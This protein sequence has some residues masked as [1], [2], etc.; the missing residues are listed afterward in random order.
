M[1]SFI[2]REKRGRANLQSATTHNG[3]EDHRACFCTRKQSW[4]Y[5]L[6][7][8]FIL[9]PLPFFVSVLSLFLW[10]FSFHPFFPHPFLFSSLLLLFLFYVLFLCEEMKALLI[11]LKER[12]KRELT[13]MNCTI[14]QDPSD[15]KDFTIMQTVF[16][17]LKSLYCICLLFTS[18]PLPSPLPP[19][20]PSP[21]TLPLPFPLPHNFLHYLCSGNAMICIISTFN[22][23]Q[24][25]SLLQR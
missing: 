19:P 9:L 21:L 14:A 6:F 3:G 4:R 10:S 1:Q 2:A 7:H 5:V 17:Y 20:P 16:N 25:K 8:L 24:I 15:K 23:L 22:L 11:Q 12:T 13:C 18:L